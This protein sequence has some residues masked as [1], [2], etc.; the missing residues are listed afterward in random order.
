MLNELYDFLHLFF[1]VQYM[2]IIYIECAIINL[3]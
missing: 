3:S 2:F 1:F